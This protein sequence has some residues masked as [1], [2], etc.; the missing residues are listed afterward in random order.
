[1]QLLD[2]LIYWRIKFFVL[3]FIFKFI[4]RVFSYFFLSLLIPYS[5]LIS[6][7]LYLKDSFCSWYVNI[8][9]LLW[10]SSDYKFLYTLRAFHSEFI[11]FSRMK[12]TNP[13]L[14][15]IESDSFSDHILTTFTSYMERS[16]VSHFI[17]SNSFTLYDIKRLFVRDLTFFL[18]DIWWIVI[19]ANIKVVSTS[20]GKWTHFFI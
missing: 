18:W 15:S 11:N 3:Y 1:M 19:F 2:R 10:V 4:K 6:T 17:S 20:C 7:I 9:T 16:F 13:S 8:I 14:K 5:A 12:V